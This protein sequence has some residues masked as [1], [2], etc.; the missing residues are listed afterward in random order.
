MQQP[1]RNMTTIP[2]DRQ[3]T[4]PHFTYETKL[5]VHTAHPASNG[6]ML[7]YTFTRLLLA[8]EK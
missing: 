5:L 4:L 6:L 1:H 3:G 2:G 8:H 7:R